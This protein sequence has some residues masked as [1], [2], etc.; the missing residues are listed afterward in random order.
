MGVGGVTEKKHCKEKK[1]SKMSPHQPP[2][3]CRAAL[4]SFCACGAGGEAVVAGGGG[5]A[6]GLLRGGDKRGLRLTAT[7]LSVVCRLSTKT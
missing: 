3:R 4:L 7:S 6:E 5:G 1:R 2:G